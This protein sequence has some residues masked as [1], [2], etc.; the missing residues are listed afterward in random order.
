MKALLTVCGMT[1]DGGGVTTCL[2][3]LAE[4][5]TALSG[6]DTVRLLTIKEDKGTIGEGSRWLITVPSD[7]RTPLKL[8]RNL[9]HALAQSTADVMH[10]HGLWAHVNHLTAKEAR[11]RD[12]PFILSPHGMLFPQALKR[13]AWKKRPLELLWFNRDI[14]RADAIHVT[15][16]EEGEH[17]RSF[18]Y[19]GRIEVIPNPFV[20]P[21]Y[22]EQVVS[23]RESEG[24]GDKPKTLGF[25]GRLHPV[26]GV[27]YLIDALALMNDKS[28]RLEIMG[29]GEDTYVSALR[30][31]AVQRGVADRIDWVGP[32][33][34]REKFE[35]LAR[36]TALV[37]PSDFENFGMIVPE[38]LIVETPVVASDT[39]PWQSLERNQCGR[40]ID[41][42]P[43]NLGTVLDEMVAMPATELRAMGKRGAQ[44]T[45]REFAAEVVARRMLDLYKSLL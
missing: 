42:A 35:R 24:G 39:T 31:R 20:I 16:K 27:E 3:D 45:R 2:R 15:C 37:V 38:S 14:K 22:I 36:L 28:V 29:A 19:K 40:W 43:A 7:Y 4:S 18:G 34:G 32:V 41:R 21:D 6:D 23:G 33:A 5:M 26:K 11:R 30:E 17:V 9:K 12:I 13:S 25:L 1:A 8:S 10:T 44:M